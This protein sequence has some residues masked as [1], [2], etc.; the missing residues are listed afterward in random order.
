MLCFRLAT[1]PTHSLFGPIRRW[2]DAGVYWAQLRKR[3]RALAFPVPSSNILLREDCAQ[4]PQE[5]LNLGSRSDAE[6]PL[7]MRLFT[8]ATKVR[9]CP[10]GYLEVLGDSSA[11]VCKKA[12]AQSFPR[13]SRLH[14]ARISFYI[15]RTRLR[16]APHTPRKLSAHKAWLSGIAKS[17]CKSRSFLRLLAPG[18][19]SKG[20]Q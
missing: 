1:P 12:E 10:R 4:A 17:D 8:A 14:R 13:G 5:V 9:T 16:P 3:S 7:P 15:S 11:P 18:Q 6:C 19:C 2:K 20:F